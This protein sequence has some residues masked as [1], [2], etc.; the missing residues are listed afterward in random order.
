MKIYKKRSLLMI[1]AFALI[2]PLLF[3]IGPVAAFADDDKSM[4][5]SCVKDGTIITGMKW[6]IYR[7]GERQQGEFV[8][9]DDF[10][11][12][13]VDLKD[14]SARNI[15]AAAQTL[16]GLALEKSIPVLAMGETDNDGTVTFSGLRNGLYLAVGHKIKQGDYTYEP[17]PLLLEISDEK[18]GF[19]F[20]AY[21]KIVKATLANE[22][23]SHTVRKVWLDFND[24]YE[25]RPTYVTV[26]IF[27]DDELFD[28]VTLN[29]TNN[30]E[31]RWTSLDAQYEWKVV[32]RQIPVD[33]TVRVEQNETQYLICNRHKAV[34]DWDEFEIQFPVTTTTVPPV[35]TGDEGSNT[36]E[37]IQ[38]TDKYTMTTSTTAETTLPPA[39]TPPQQSTNTGGGRSKLPQTGQLWWPVA[40]L[41]FGGT[42]LV[43]TGM[44]LK[45]KKDEDEE[46]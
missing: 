29:E 45:S 21:P 3:R 43:F 27:R 41:G 38:T 15:M 13:P 17:S 12:F 44:K 42:V 20:D 25:A 7:I 5:L 46:E 1:L 36:A 35:V 19:S 23:T 4:T 31:H 2:I 18:A 30:W 14:M 11:G 37:T 40:P 26:D 10:S 39:T 24:N 22:A 33:Y 32:E 6:K 8:L 28:T 16:D 34:L 9:T